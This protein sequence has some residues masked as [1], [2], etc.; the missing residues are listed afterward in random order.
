VEAEAPLQPN[1]ASAEA[2]QTQ[3]AAVDQNPVAEAQNPVK[4]MAAVDQTLAAPHQTWPAAEADQTLAARPSAAVAD[5]P[6]SA[7]VIS[8]QAEDRPLP[9]SFLRVC[10]AQPRSASPYWKIRVPRKQRFAAMATQP[11]RYRKSL[12]VVGRN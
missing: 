12:L 6:H 8:A 4:V 3:A 9:T 1:P 11:E 7:Q 5:V 10:L 2:L